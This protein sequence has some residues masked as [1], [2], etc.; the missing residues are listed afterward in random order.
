MAG[1]LQRVPETSSNVE[2][3]KHAITINQ[4]IGRY[5]DSGVSIDHGTLA[6]LT[7]DDHTQY[8]NTT[9]LTAVL[10]DYALT[11]DLA[12]YYTIVSAD[13]TFAP[14]SHTH[15]TSDITNLS[16]Y[17]GFDARYYTETE[18][19]ALLAAKA[20][21]SITLTAGVG[22]TG[23]GDLSAN[24]SFALDIPGLTADASPVGSTDYIVTYDASAATHKKV[25]LDDLPSGSA[26]PLTTKG[27][28]WG[29]ST[30][31]ARLPV[32]T[33]GYVLTADSAETLGIKWAAA[34][35]G[36]GS[37][38]VND[39]C[40]VTRT[41][42]AQSISHA[43]ETAL[44]FDTEDRDDNGYWTVSNPTRL[45]APAT[46]WYVVHAGT[47]WGST[48]GGF[49]RTLYLRI[50]GTTG[51]EGARSDL[52]V[53]TANNAQ[54]VSGIVYLT[55]GDYVEAIVYQDSGSSDSISTGTSGQRPGM[56]MHR[57]GTSLDITA[58]TA[59]TVTDTAADY[60]V[61]YD[62]SAGVNKKVLL[63]DLGITGGGGSGGAVD[64]G[65]EVRRTTSQTLTTANTEYAISFDTEV[66][67]D[68]G[69]WVA[70]SP[71]I[72]T[73]PESGWY[74][75]T[76]G[77]V[78]AA[79]A[80]AS[81]IRFS[82]NSAA[83]AIGDMI[84]RHA[85]GSISM[86]EVGGKAVY[87]SAG[88]TVALVAASAQASQS[89]TSAYMTIHRLGARTPAFSGVKVYHSTTQVVSGTAI[90][91]AWDSETYD[92]DGYHDTSTNNSRLTAP[93]DGYYDIGWW[94]FFSAAGFHDIT[95]RKNGTTNIESW[96][97]GI[98]FNTSARYGTRVT[99]YL[100]AGDYV[101]L[102]VVQT[103]GG[104]LN[105]GAN[106]SNFYMTRLGT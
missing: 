27:D 21:E 22:L 105:G 57:L 104:N 29:Y 63:E 98:N 58:L 3:L 10:A 60:A 84:S 32:G 12:A 49:V 82:I 18:A 96:G 37:A 55:A 23:G 48:S 72:F 41:G 34:T 94:V 43:T 101:E 26:S 99:H 54:S 70:G 81:Y 78:F 62:A 35:G 75:L 106:T 85:G 15:T 17:T 52:S 79:T 61:I 28:L 44:S 7:D 4:L 76:G 102:R 53:G 13:A 80:Q 6:G 65:C 39:G 40:R 100:N 50:N 86:Y 46:G 83:L 1:E 45:T 33:D 92:T 56:S 90:T 9:R 2:I 30:V 89:V 24:R 97:P 73:I 25:L 36:S 88:D 69:Y 66:R 93:T 67:D 74:I 31:D 64:D 16:S 38:I 87:L 51:V 95:I 77:A 71:T 8:Y 42:A 68:N 11:T 103:G 91:V 59:E 5:L 20:D 47:R 19:D 14:I